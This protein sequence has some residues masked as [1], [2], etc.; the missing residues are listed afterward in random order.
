VLKDQLEAA[1]LGKKGKRVSSFQ[2]GFQ[3]PGLT[4][5]LGADDDENANAD[6]YDEA[7]EAAAAAE[8]AVELV[9]TCKTRRTV[10]PFWTC[11]F[12]CKCS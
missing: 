8:E 6:E 12:F 9:C 1:G 2:K 10:P 7:A 11:I 5:T 3:N 4:E